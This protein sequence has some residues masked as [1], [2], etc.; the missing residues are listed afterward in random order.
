MGV[1]IARLR[2]WC[3]AKAVMASDATP[4]DLLPIDKDTPRLKQE[5]Y[6]NA[7]APND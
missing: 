5:I 7:F 4:E 2:K 3:Q 1:E 6:N